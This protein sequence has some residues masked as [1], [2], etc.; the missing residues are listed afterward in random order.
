MLLD[1][2][3]SRLSEL[4]DINKAGS[5]GKGPSG[6]AAARHATYMAAPATLLL[7]DTRVSARLPLDSP[8]EWRLMGF[9]CSW[10][11]AAD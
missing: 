1:G 11:K 8:G 10:R 3:I 4:L 7:L 9:G 5:G 2:F 6:I